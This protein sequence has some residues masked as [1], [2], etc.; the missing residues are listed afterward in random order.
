MKKGL[1]MLLLF[2]AC[3]GMLF[4][5]ASYI[6]E[7][8]GNTEVNGTYVENGTWNDKP[9]YK[10]NNDGTI[11]VLGFSEVNGQWCIGTQY[12]WEWMPDYYNFSS[13]DTPPS[14]GWLRRM[15]MPPAPT[16]TLAGRTISYNTKV[17]T[18]SNNNDGSIS[19]SIVMTYNEFAGDALTGNINDNFITSNKINI[20]N[21]P[22]GLTAS[23]IKTASNQLTFSLS[24]HATNHAQQN[25]VY[26][27]TLTFQNSAFTQSN[28]SEV[29][30]YSQSDIGILYMITFS[31]GAGT[32]V[33]PYL[34]ANKTDLRILSENWGG[35]LW[36][37]YYAQS[38]NISF[39]TS[40]FQT[41]GNFYNGG[42]GWI[43]IGSQSN[44]FIGQYNGQTHT[45]DGLF[46]NRTTACQGLFGYLNGTTA[47]VENLGVLNANVAGQQFT[48]VLVGWNSGGVISNSYTTGIVSG[49]FSR[50]GGLVGENYAGAIS[51]SYSTCIVT[52]SSLIGGLAGQ[53]DNG[54][55]SNSYSI[56]N[57]SGNDR[58]GGLVG[59]NNS[60]I[61]NSYST[62]NVTKKTGSG[63]SETR[64][65]GF[66][67]AQY[68]STITNSYSTGS[69]SFIGYT[70]VIQT[71]KGF[72]GYNFNGS[73]S[74][75]FWDTQKSGSNSSEG[76]ATG[77]TTAEMKNID[78]F[79]TWDI[80]S[81]YN[82]SNVWNLQ[83]DVND[84]YPYLSWTNHVDDQTL[85]LTLSSFTAAYTA[86]NTVSINWQTESE[87]NM[88]GYYVY[89]STTNNVSTAHKASNIITA[90]NQTSTHNYN[91]TDFEVEYETT[92][93]YW[94]QSLAYD[95]ANEY[96]G[97]ISITTGN[98]QTTEIPQIP[99]IT[100]L[101]SAYPNPF[102]PTTTISFDLA[103]D[104]DVTID[105][106]NSK[107]QKVQSLVNN[108][109]KMGNHRVVWNGLDTHNKSCGT[110]TYFFRMKAGNY[111]K[112]TKALLIK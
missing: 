40:D 51:N 80:V 22:T 83:T 64:F 20:S 26:D 46:I 61:S 68:N 5:L 63:S 85:P 110:G 86:S 53:C 105:V 67:G 102:N 112:I 62:G 10:F 60:P 7:G 29:S 75:C 18:E 90:N 99:I 14:D 1:M 79:S 15:G 4:S 71:N 107:G 108:T 21:I 25:R 59:E 65:G 98:G 42:E 9:M 19:N 87:S 101:N 17:F 104:T 81:G 84:G 11:Y 94:L 27:I 58:V 41:G 48:G 103:T 73:F 76:T 93:Y 31:G 70:P 56:G 96:F 111:S 37:K 78:T 35:D 55:I 8:A 91:F 36:N 66:V 95:G 43:P 32:E 38:A 74:N 2:V 33:N 82:Q 16:V 44:P 49:T 34:V 23:I 72:A 109:F 50:I 45:I 6:V 39:L 89:R 13:D 88:M 57:V 100:K 3:S 97:S 52:G 69:V 92:Y 12:E 106:Y 24:G 77:K 28:A 47:K 30:N 54:S